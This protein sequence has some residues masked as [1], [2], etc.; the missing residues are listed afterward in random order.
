MPTSFLIRPIAASDDAAMASIIRHVMP[1]FGADGPGF[2]IHDAE[3]DRMC[4]AYAQPRSA[5]FVVE[6]DSQ[7]VGGG[8][9]AP[10]QNGDADVCELRK[11][12]FLPAARGIGAGSAMMQRCLDAARAFGFRRC[13]LETLTGMDAAQALYKRSGFTALC[14]PMGGTGHFSCD[15]FFILE[16]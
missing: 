4:E 12:Y 15:R 10:L 6:R 14:A 13:Y 1:E 11:M 8:G 16:L 5:Y 7:V 2:A 3:V 9:V